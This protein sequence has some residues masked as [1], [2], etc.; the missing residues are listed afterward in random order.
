MNFI[1]FLSNKHERYLQ[2]FEKS[3][4]EHINERPVGQVGNLLKLIALDQTC[5]RENKGGNA[6]GSLYKINP[7]TYRKLVNIVKNRVSKIK[8]P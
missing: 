5:V 2:L 3:I 7:E 6:G 4:N 8:S 1:D